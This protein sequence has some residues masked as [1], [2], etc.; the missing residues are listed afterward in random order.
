[1]LTA[2]L[3]KTEVCSSTEEIS[4]RKRLRDELAELQCPLCCEVFT[5]AVQ[6]MCCG[7][8]ACRACLSVVKTGLCPFC[9][10]ASFDPAACVPD[11]KLERRASTA[12]L[13]CANHMKGCSFAGDRSSRAA[14]IAAECEHVDRRAEVKDLRARV[15]QLEQSLRA[16]EEGT[17]AALRKEN[18]RLRQ[19]AA[20]AAALTAKVASQQESLTKLEQESRQLR[21][22][23]KSRQTNVEIVEKSLKAFVAGDISVL[24]SLC[25]AE[26][27]TACTVRN[28]DTATGTYEIRWRSRQGANTSHSF[29]AYLHVENFNVSFFVRCT[30]TDAAVTSCTVMI[31]HPTDP[32]K[33]WRCPKVIC[34]GGDYVGRRNLMTLDQLKTYIVCKKMYL[35]V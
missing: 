11:I 16:V 1:M 17:V 28:E 22:R 33:S 14:H 15:Q 7:A 27:V 25:R 35:A 18:E 29:D 19:D 12:K 4:D 6:C 24:K 8:N 26:V 3:V 13:P 31:L 32:S 30:S 21:L 23:F 9:R 10:N 5:D 20:Q 2:T 34:S